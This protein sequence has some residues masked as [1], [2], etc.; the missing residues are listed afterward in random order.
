M[1]C[2]YPLEYIAVLEGNCVQF[3]SLSIALIS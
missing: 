1:D 2:K 3:E